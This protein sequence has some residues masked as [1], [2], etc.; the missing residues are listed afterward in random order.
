MGTWRRFWT[1]EVTQGKGLM[2]NRVLFQSLKR[3]KRRKSYSVPQST[4]CMK[5]LIALMSPSST[6]L[7]S[8]FVALAFAEEYCELKAR[9]NAFLIS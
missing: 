9:I 8:R 3:K 5:L 1:W 2:G 7:G 4:S 6:G